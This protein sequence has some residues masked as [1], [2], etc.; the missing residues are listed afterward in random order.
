[1]PSSV[2]IKKHVFRNIFYKINNVYGDENFGVKNFLTPK[3]RKRDVTFVTLYV[4]EIFHPCIAYNLR[5]K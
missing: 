1:M 4:L 5:M 3:K 2:T